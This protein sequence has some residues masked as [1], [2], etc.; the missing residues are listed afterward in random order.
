VSTIEKV[1]DNQE[2]KAKTEKLGF[3][4]DYKPPAESKKLIDENYERAVQIAEKLGIRK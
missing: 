3:I 4:V 1:I 2:L